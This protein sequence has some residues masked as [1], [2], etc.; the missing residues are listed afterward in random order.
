MGDLTTNWIR[1]AAALLAGLLLA[2]PI[3]PPIEQAAGVN[4]STALVAVTGGTTVVLAAIWHT[5]ATILEK[6]WPALGILLGIANSA[7]SYGTGTGPVTGSTAQL[8][9]AETLAAQ[10]PGVTV[11]QLPTHSA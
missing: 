6:R 11:E 8:S 9:A 5:V 4:S 2:L 3:A 7:P 10:V 1:T